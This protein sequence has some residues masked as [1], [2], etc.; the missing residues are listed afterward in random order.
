MMTGAISE[1]GEHLGRLL[2]VELRER[3]FVGG[4]EHDDFVRAGCARSGVGAADDGIEV[5]HDAH[6]PP[7]RVGRAVARA[8]HL[9]RR[10][11]LVAGAERAARRR[12]RASA[13]GRRERVRA[14]RAPGCEEH[15]TTAQLVPPQLG[16]GAQARG[17]PYPGC[18]TRIS[19]VRLVILGGGPAGN[20]CATVA[21]T[22]GAEVTLV[23]RD[24]I[25]GAAHLWDCIPS[26][27]M[28]ATGGE[29][30]ELGPQPRDGPAGRGRRRPRR[31]ARARL[32]DRAA[33]ARV[34]RAAARVAEGPAA[35]RHRAAQG[36]A[37]GRGRDRPRHR[38]ARSRLHRGRHR[39]RG[40]GSPSSRPST[41]S[42]CSPPARRTRRPS[43]PSTSW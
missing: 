4:G 15:P 27:A 19:G 32:V 40:P 18:V 35:P 2:L 26:K 37:R 20:T 6:A 28:I 3:G 25:G 10:Q 41:A 24:V 11:V 16:H 1:D 5:R 9:G 13:R 8:V 30:A 17:V 29:L 42:G 21:A 31:A 34:D 14:R 39:A 36:P 23:E 7:G 12:V 22:L 38:G 43:C 33:P